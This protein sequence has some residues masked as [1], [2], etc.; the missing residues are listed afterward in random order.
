MNKNARKT[1]KKNS[2]HQFS[3][4]QEPESW[5][6]YTKVDTS[7]IKALQLTISQVESKERPFNV[8]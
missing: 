2:F 3:G 7:S 8:E 6:K 5:W 4:A 1:A